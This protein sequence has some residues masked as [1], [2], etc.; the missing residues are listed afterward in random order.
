MFWAFAA[1]VLILLVTI[2]VSNR[3]AVRIA[4][5]VVLAGLLAWGLVQRLA[6]K[7]GLETERGK[8]SSP[9][10]AIEAM[11]LSAVAVSELQLT[12]GGAPFELRGVI[13]NHSAATRLRSITLRIAR[14]DCF[15]GAIDPTGCVVTWQD[16]HWIQMDVLPMTQRR[17]VSSFYARTGVPTT[18]GTVKHDFE[19][20]GATGQ[21][22]AQ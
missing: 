17:F 8:P 21:P 6:M 13:D 7:P 3:G 15:E 14:R 16:Q 4:G 5:S 1:V 18:R 2:T 19:L 12:G 10:A 11:P 9:A 22:I 20:V